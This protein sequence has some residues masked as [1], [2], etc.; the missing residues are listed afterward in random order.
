MVMKHLKLHAYCAH[1]MSGLRVQEETKRMCVG[2]EV[3]TAESM[4]ITLMTEAARTS[5]T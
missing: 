2:F 5:E 4:K 3:F 1:I